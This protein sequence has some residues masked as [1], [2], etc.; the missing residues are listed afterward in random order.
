V[1]LSKYQRRALRRSLELRDQPFPIFGS[2]CKAWKSY[3][4]MFALFAGYIWWTWY[5]GLTEFSIAALGGF[6]GVLVRD[7]GWFR[8]SARMWPVNVEVIDWVKVEKLLDEQE[9]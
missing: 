1:E 4:I 2:I 8:A 3:L 5:V 9:K 7:L 6:I